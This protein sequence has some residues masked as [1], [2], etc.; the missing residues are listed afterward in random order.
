MHGGFSTS[1]CV[2]ACASGLAR[3][4]RFMG[5]GEV[6]SLTSLPLLTIPFK[7]P[8]SRA[9]HKHAHAHFHRHKYTHTHTHTHTLT[10]TFTHTYSHTHTHKQIHRQT[11][12]DTHSNI[13]TE[14]SPGRPQT[15]HQIARLSG[16]LIAMASPATIQRHAPAD[17]I[18]PP[19]APPSGPSGTGAPDLRA[20][21]VHPP[22]SFPQHS[23]LF[24]PSSPTFLTS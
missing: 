4:A 16:P 8:A 9:L 10:H 3:R 22:L 11:D 21:A 7:K 14:A 19:P 24:L 17:H 2:C 5:C 20:A 15:S 13:P 1:K 18:P 6:V 23:A 12:T